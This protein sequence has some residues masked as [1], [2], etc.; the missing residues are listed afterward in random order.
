VCLLLFCVSYAACL[1]LLA[2][3]CLHAR[4]Q[5][6][7]L[8]GPDPIDSLSLC[9]CAERERAKE[10]LRETEKE[11]AREGER[12]KGREGERERGRGRERGPLAALLRER[13]AER[14]IGRKRERA[15]ER[16]LPASPRS[17]CLALRCFRCSR[18][19]VL[20]YRPV[21]ACALLLSP[22]PCPPPPFTQNEGN[23]VRESHLVPS[24]GRSRPTT[25]PCQPD[26]PGAWYHGFRACR[27][28][29]P[30][31]PCR[32]FRLRTDGCW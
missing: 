30:G 5:G 18:T 22:A 1:A 25:C 21:S 6:N 23:I 11:G 8:P 17:P 29:R 24:S 27:P 14:G 13:E 26:G 31:L 19:V 7:W 10:S 15:R 20:L 12:E 2:P 16:P 4:R 28:F 32:Q 3:I 9:R